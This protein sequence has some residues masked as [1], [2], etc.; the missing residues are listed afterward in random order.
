MYLS[1]H[2][3]DASEAVTSSLTVRYRSEVVG[4]LDVD[5]L[6]KADSVIDADAKVHSLRPAAPVAIAIG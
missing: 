2:A 3:S 6:A 4:T 5:V 1:M